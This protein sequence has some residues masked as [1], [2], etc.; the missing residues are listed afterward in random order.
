MQ[1][2]YIYFSLVLSINLSKLD[3]KCITC[4]ATDALDA[5]INLFKLDFK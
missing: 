2:L 3:F 4:T 1:E 5:S